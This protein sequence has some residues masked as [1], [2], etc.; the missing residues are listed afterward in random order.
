M[1]IEYE[2]NEYLFKILY[3]IRINLPSSQFIYIIMFLLKYIG[4]ILFSVSL[5]E[6]NNNIS[7]QKKENIFNNKKHNSDI[8]YSIL[9]I[10]LINSNNLKILNNHYQVICSVGFYILII[11]ILLIIFGFVY[12]KKKYYNKKSIS[13]IEKKINKLDK[14]SNFEKIFFKILTYIFFLIVFFHQYIIEYYIFGFL[15]YILNYLNAFSQSFFET[16]KNEYSSSIE[17]HLSNI[18]D[19]IYGIIVINAL[20]I[21][22]ILIFYIIFI[23]I[24][25]YKTL[26]FENGFPLYSNK[27]NFFVKLIIFNFNPLFG[28]FNTF[29]N[30]IKI[31]IAI[32]FYIILIIILLINIIILYYNFTSYP[33][34]MSSIF[35][36]LEFFLL[37]SFISELIIYLT[38][39]YNNTFK[40]NIIKIIIELVNSIFLTILF[41]FK[42]E[43]YSTNL[44]ETNLFNKTFKLLNHDDI[45]YYFKIY[46]RYSINKEKNYLKIFRLIQS[47]II[48]CNKQDCPCKKL[49][50]KEMSYS[51]FTDFSKIKKN[52]TYNINYT[53]NEEKVIDN[54]SNQQMSDINIH[55]SKMNNIESTDNKSI[56]SIKDDLFEI[57]NN[58]LK[59]KKTNATQKETDKNEK[60]T[61]PVSSL[62]SKN[63]IIEKK[64]FIFKSNNEITNEEEELIKKKLTDKQFQIIGEQEIINRINY[65]YRQKNYNDLAIYIFIHLQYLI[66]IK[67]NYRL[68]L[69]FI[70]K[71]SSTDLKLN[72]LSKYFLYEMKKYIC[73]SILSTKSVNLIQDPFINKY[74]KENSM[75]KKLFNYFGNY[76]IIKN[77]IR[78]SCKKIIYFYN[79]RAELHS[80]LFIQKYSKLKASPIINSAEELESSISKLNFLIDKIYK[81]QNNNIESIELSYLICNFFQLIEG[82]ISQEKLKKITPIFYFKQSH[83]DNLKN[84]YHQFMMSEPMIIS[85]TNKDTFDVVYFTNNIL[86]KLGYNYLDLMNKDFHEK[87]FPGEELLIKEHSLILKQFLFFYNNTYSKSKTFIKS[88]EGFLVPI[89]FTCKSFPNYINNFSLIADI[90]F[91]EESVKNNNY[92]TQYSTK[93]NFFNNENLITNSYYFFLNSDFDCFGLTKNFFLEYNLNQNMFR[94]LRINFCQFFSINENRLV[95]QIRKE[96]I[97]IFKK[98]PNLNHKLSLKDLNKAYTMFQD[99]KLNNIFKLRD[100]KI[101]ENYFFPTIDIYDRIDKK[102]LI[103][104]IPEIISIIEEIGLDYDWYLKLQNFKERLNYNNIF[105]NQKNSLIT[106][107]NINHEKTIKN[108]ENNIEINQFHNP[109]QF[110]EV[111]YSLKRLGSLIYCIVN[112]QET[113]DISFEN[114]QILNEE[115][116]ISKRTTKNMNNSN[117]KKIN[118]KTTLK[119][120]E[121]KELKNLENEEGETTSLKLKSK[122]KVSFH[123]SLFKKNALKINKTNN[124]KQIKNENIKNNIENNDINNSKKESSKDVNINI[125]E[126]LKNEKATFYDNTEY[127]NRL[128]SKK[129]EFFDEEEDSPLITKDKFNEF[130]QKNKKRN[131][132]MIILI[133][134][135]IIIILILIVIQIIFTCQG[136]DNAKNILNSSNY[137]EMLKVDVY[138]E[139]ILSIIYCVYEND[140]ILNIKEL[141]NMAKKR[142]IIILEH[143]KLLQDQINIILNNKDSIRIFEI[144]EERILINTLESDWNV[145]HKKVDIL[146]EIRSLSYNIYGLTSIDGKCDI[147]L[148]Y[149][150]FIKKGEKFNASKKNAN[151]IQKIFFYFASNILDNYKKTFDRLSE[152]FVYS[153][154]NIWKNFINYLLILIFLILLIIISFIVVYIIK[155]CYDFSYY[156]LLFLYYYYIEEEQLEFEN[157]IYYLYQTVTDFNYDNINYFENVKINSKNIEFNEDIR[158]TISKF[159]KINVN[160]NINNSFTNQKNIF[161]RTSISHKNSKEEKKVFEQ[162]S[163]N[164]N[165]L[166]GSIN[167]SSYQLLNNLNNKIPLNNNIGNN[168]NSFLQNINDKEQKNNLQEDSE[169]S[170]L[171]LSNKIIPNHLK[172][173]L[174]LIIAFCLIFIIITIIYIYKVNAQGNTWNLSI[175]LSMNIMEGNPNLMITLIYV[176]LSII[177]KKLNLIEGSAFKDNQPNYLKYF[178]VNKLYYSKHIIEKY[179]ANNYFGELI[180]D[181]LRINYNLDDNL[182]KNVDNFKNTIKWMEILNSRGDYCIYATL[183][184]ILSSQEQLN[185]Y[186]ILNTLNEKVLMCIDDNTG[187]NESGTKLQISYILDEITNKYIEFMDYNESIITFDTL[188]D[189]FFNSNQIKKI[190]LDMQYSLILNFNTITYGVRLDFDILNKNIQNIQKILVL[191]LFGII[192]LIIII[193]PFGIFKD[194]NHKYLFGFFAEIPK[195]NNYN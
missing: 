132:I 51:F 10:F 168:N 50:P 116:E 187:I 34:V 127:L 175:N 194:E 73:K 69:Y 1:N 98:N 162:N 114:L 3:L 153:L 28:I 125:K 155:V 56:I 195:I 66:K 150:Y 112:F 136:Y 46:L 134:S 185:V 15:G 42:K 138:C 78:V 19:N 94:E 141:Q 172:I 101:L 27:K 40:F 188:R 96:R 113:I 161:K 71:Y 140:E 52:D 18:D 109:T 75:I 61:L 58:N 106:N 77:L 97:K 82:R 174:I 142:L 117:I 149:D 179:F 110:F 145:T 84:E 122:N 129:K 186:D 24:N 36:F 68:A 60:N 147:Q 16:T 176:C 180:R 7:S 123:D 191:F 143:L 9:S 177:T 86:E 118:T 173:S 170:I 83:Y 45:Y 121:I 37:I 38:N 22:M 159:V 43:E 54:N 79:V 47:H 53:N 62:N 181:D 184:D 2:K 81:E 182:P 190:F 25:S 100:E 120:K 105:E 17:N 85:L 108:I 57:K 26:F 63:A 49:F 158:K 70:C 41:I 35:I 80:P 126:K 99:I 192:I 91:N 156:Q 124:E 152:E 107:K 103:H 23:I 128:K 115:D 144:I 44:F 87:L 89:N 133:F 151:N 171:N 167:G 169:D 163:N 148:F 111:T 76:F 102:K 104:K 193:L 157:K 164:G 93:T 8:I 137:F 65:L 139:A 72:F 165:I 67:K 39:S 6:W 12:M 92:S 90:T 64:S 183:G 74:K 30:Q 4:L 119:A 135:L 59:R 11:Y 88:K 131:K 146:D 160:N 130:I 14:K 13:I 95:E 29:N 21:F 32:I 166:N 5:N 154:E 33:S 178:K 20:T 189:N 48:S 31:K 55:N